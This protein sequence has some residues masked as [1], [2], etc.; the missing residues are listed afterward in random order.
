MAVRPRLTENVK[1]TP[2]LLGQL[3]TARN[4]GAKSDRRINRTRLALLE[5]VLRLCAT[6]AIEGVSI[7]D[8]ANEDQVAKGRYHNHLMLQNSTD[9]QKPFELLVAKMIPL[10]VGVP[11]GL[12]FNSKAVAAAAKAAAKSTLE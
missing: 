1:L 7:D 12:G 8:I 9:R 3:D 6:R 2:S 4:Q 10:M 11:K 5:A